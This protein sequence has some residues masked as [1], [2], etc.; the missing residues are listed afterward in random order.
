MYFNYKCKLQAY[1]QKVD[2]TLIHITL[3]MKEN[4]QEISEKYFK[5]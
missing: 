1:R 4:A 5:Y 3:T 2:H